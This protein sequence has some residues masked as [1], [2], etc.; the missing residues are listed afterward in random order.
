[1]RQSLQKTPDLL[2][3]LK[4]AGVVDSGGAGLVCIFEGMLAVLR[5]EEIQDDQP[6]LAETFVHPSAFDENSQLTYGYC[7]EFILQLMHSKTDLSAFS[8][9]ARGTVKKLTKRNAVSISPVATGDQ[10]GEC[11]SAVGLAVAF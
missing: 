11:V 6:Q 9:T 1:M 3:V 5:G 4:E 10:R 8:L 2:P 7:T